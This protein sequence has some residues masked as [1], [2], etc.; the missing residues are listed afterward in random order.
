M[1]SSL[2][3]A[4]VDSTRADRMKY[5]SGAAMKEIDFYKLPRAV[6]DQLVASVRARAAPL[7]ILMSTTPSRE[8]RVWLGV[9]GSGAALLVGL[10]VVG[11]GELASSAAAHGAAFAPLWIL[12][13]AAVAAGVLRVLALRRDARVAHVP[14]GTYVFPACLVDAHGARLRVHATSD[15]V[16]TEAAATAQGGPAVKLVFPDGV[17]HV[18]P[19]ADAEQVATVERAL[20]DARAQLAR[21]QAAG[22]PRSVAMLDPLYDSAF[23]SPLGPTEPL[24]RDQAQWAKL[25]WAV[26]LGVGVVVGPALLLARN[27]RSDAKL[28]ARAVELD[29]VAAYR[30]YVARGTAHRAEVEGTLLPRAELREAKKAGTV[31]AIERY[32]AEHP[33]TNIQK[34]VAAAL[35]AAMLV[36]LDEAKKQGTLAALKDFAQRHPAHGV[37]AE[38]KGATHAVYVAAL[39]RYRAR[40]TDNAEHVAF[41]E[42]M[43]AW[44]EAKGPKVEVRFRRRAAKSMQ[45]AD[46]Q[47]QKSKQ[48]T[49]TAAIPSRYFDASHA[50]PREQ[51]LVA[52][53][54]GR[55]AEVFPA[56]ILD[57]V[58]GE[59][60][61]DPDATTPAPSVPTLFVDHVVE[62]S[63]TT[64]PVK[65]PRGI[66]AGAIFG[67]D[68]TFRLPDPPPVKAVKVK[69]DLWRPA[70]VSV[71]KEEK[72]ESRVYEVMARDAF[73]Q[74]AKKVGSAFFKGAPKR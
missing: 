67:F 57:V 64:Y 2:R 62:W 32:A 58:P 44:V 4:R 35:H 12:G 49:G 26:A 17:A 46:A 8:P 31:Q 24:K 69:L 40:A 73:D 38:L 19:V 5:H 60:I 28:Y 15:M 7:P 59:H 66:F 1:A 71:F 3:R 52:Q 63:G 25:F 36:E 27:A 65:E 6:Q 39:E 16:A 9:A 29:D 51:A 33:R 13:A 23:S 37:E 56:E 34:E 21:A 30:A 72:K 20:A 10:W 41:I 45:K 22:D 47:I 61:A 14:P 70:D 43:V 50:A 74:Y 55:F 54:G 18:F 48:F 42:K 68:G 53:I 11:N